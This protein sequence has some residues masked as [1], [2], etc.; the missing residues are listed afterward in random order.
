MKAIFLLL[1]MM[2]LATSAF[3]Y[4]SNPKNIRV[5]GNKVIVDA[6]NFEAVLSVTGEYL[7]THMVFGGSYF[8]EKN[9]VNPVSLSVLEIADARDIYKKYPDFHMCKSAGAHLAQNKVRNLNLIPADQKSLKE[10]RA[11][12]EEHEENFAAGRERICIT[13]T[14]K[15][16]SPDSKEV[17]GRDSTGDMRMIYA[18]PPGPYYLI[19]SAKRLE[20]KKLLD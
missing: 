2:A 5:R 20:C 11:L 17:Q 19:Q 8:Q 4:Y 3:Y 9:L 13:L 1:I 7:Q 12:I 18:I 14:G 16:L 15:T 6:G 10:L